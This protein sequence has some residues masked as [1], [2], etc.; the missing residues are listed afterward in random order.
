MSDLRNEIA[1][2]IHAIRHTASNTERRVAQERLDEIKAAMNSM[3]QQPTSWWSRL[4]NRD[5]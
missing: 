5:R 4:W 1:S 2:L 3:P